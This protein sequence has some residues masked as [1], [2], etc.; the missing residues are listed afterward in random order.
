MAKAKKMKAVSSKKEKDKKT[1]T[2][3]SAKGKASKGSKGKSSSKGGGGGP[4]ASLTKEAKKRNSPAMITG[5]IAPA[6]SLSVKLEAVNVMRDLHQGIQVTKISQNGRFHKRYLT[7]SKDQSL[8]FV[9][10][11]KVS[12]E[13]VA[14][15]L[16][17]PMWTPSKGFNAVYQRYI[18]VADIAYWTVGV[19]GSQVLE[20]FL[21]K[22][23]KEEFKRNLITI[24]H[25]EYV[26][27]RSLNLLVENPGHKMALI[28]ALTLMKQVYDEYQIWVSREV[29]LLR[30]IWYDID[31]DKNSMV[32]EQEFVKICERINFYI[33][34]VTKQF[35]QFLKKN[36]VTGKELTYHEC[37]RLLQSL[38]ANGDVTAFVWKS[39]FGDKDEVNAK[40][41]YSK[42]LAGSQGE[43]GVSIQNAE[44]LIASVNAMEMDKAAAPKSSTKL[45]KARFAELLRSEWNDAFDPEQQKSPRKP[46]TRPITEYWI[47]ASHN[48]YLTGD[49]VQS[50]SSV[51]AYMLAM[52]RGCKCL[53][54][55]CW[56]GK[57]KRGEYLPVVYHGH[58][59]TSKIKFRDIILVV[60]NYL[61]ANPNSYPII[62]SLENHCSRPYQQAMA[63]NMKDIFGPR[64]F[65][66][67]SAQRAKDLPTPEE[68]QGM[69]IIKGKR[70]P[71]PDEGGDADSPKES[72]SKTND[73]FDEMAEKFQSDDRDL[74]RNSAFVPKSMYISDTNGKVDKVPKYADELLEL[75]L[76]HGTKFKFFEDSIEMIPSHMH[77]IGETKIS[78]IAGEY[79]DT[80]GLWRK[81]N[82][83]HMTRT[84]P[85]GKRVDSSNYNPVQAWS[86]GCQM[87]ALNFQTHDA[88]LLLN[89][90]RFRQFGNCGYV[91]KPKSVTGGEAPSPINVKIKVLGGS[92]LPKPNGEK[93]GEAIDPY[94]KVELHDVKIRNNGKEQYYTEASMTKTVNDNGFCPV[95]E[96]KGKQF[97]VVNTDVAMLLFQMVDEDIGLGDKIAS[98]AIPVS[99]LRQGFRSVQL[100]DHHN[101]RVGPFHYATLLVHI[102]MF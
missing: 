51:E 76:F 20:T 45:S 39:L 71:E 62:L 35:R 13:A 67:S 27:R 43:P 83:G 93:I 55:D 80:P 57:Q 44:D 11:S 17:K 64:L 82:I 30:Y 36:N 66:P 14:G 81:Y 96:H 19:A 26:G 79:I 90:G 59:V 63:K 10:H 7:L 68:C 88:N 28:A 38:K 47:N 61:Q 24:Y 18:D 6:H 2:K 73:A 4:Y 72:A 98:A 75:T 58:T 22:K 78:K 94:V 48:T 95:W 65:I 86:L 102:E 60:N 9:T 46:L 31:M 77:S 3:S 70:P 91:L 29:L 34:D 37:M 87:V 32:S 84:Y 21:D 8:I 97:N 40:T 50:K 49:Q 42:F 23:Q 1:K 85:A 25:A 101:S 41:F 74:N 99:C 52:L 56:D 12:D 89:D 15:R 53:E 69:V 33:K 5:G 100:Y 92:C 16:A 54:L